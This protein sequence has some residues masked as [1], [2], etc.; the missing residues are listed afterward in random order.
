M[1]Q[2]QRIN[3]LRGRLEALKLRTTGA[4]ALHHLQWACDALE[5]AENARFAIQEAERIEEQVLSMGRG[6]SLTYR[7]SVHSLETIDL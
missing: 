4:D 7:I 6:P 2:T 1:T 5:I 3:A